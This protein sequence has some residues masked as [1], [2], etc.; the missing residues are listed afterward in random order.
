[1]NIYWY[2]GSDGTTSPDY[3]DHIR[4]SYMDAI[5]RNI[6]H[7]WSMASVFAPIIETPGADSNPFA[8]IGVIEEVKNFIQEL[9]PHFIVTAD[10]SGPAP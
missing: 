8:E 9:A 5:F 1:M 4:L 10:S 3:Y 7:R 6:N 2:V